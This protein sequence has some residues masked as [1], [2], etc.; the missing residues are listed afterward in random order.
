MHSSTTEKFT[1]KVVTDISAAFAGVM[2]NLGHKLGLYKAM[3]GAGNISSSEL[4]SLTNTNE[5]YLREWL[6][7]QVAGGYVHYDEKTKKYLLPDAYIPVLVDENSPVF[8]A[9]ALQVASSLWLDEEMILD[10][11]QTGKGIAWGDHHHSLF[12]G[13]ESL[14]RPGYKA[15][16]T[17]A[18]INELD[19]VEEKLKS[20]AKV[21]DIGCGHGASTIV[22]AKAY[23]NSTFFGFDYHSSSV[24]VAKVRAKDEGL[25]ENIHFI[26]ATAKNYTEQNFDL[27]CFMDCLHDMGDPIGAAKHALNALS[28]NGTVLLIEPA[29]GDTITENINPIGRLYYSASTAICTPCSM[30]QEVGYALGAQAGEQRLSEVMIDAGFKK[31]RKV[32]ETPFNIILEVRP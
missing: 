8:L 15:H 22:M 3:A 14:F 24:N 5:R 9:P 4:A 10:A 23:P 26:S 7:S 25:A 32:A 11:L 21:A 17:T 30:S 1:E 6:N 20:G 16:L 13:S 29:A 12:C 19:G 27:I 28:D 18:W 31:I 2:T